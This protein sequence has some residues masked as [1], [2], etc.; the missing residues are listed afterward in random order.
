MTMIDWKRGGWTGSLNAWV[1]KEI[2][3]HFHKNAAVKRSRYPQF[4]QLLHTLFDNQTFGKFVAFYIGL[5]VFFGV[6]E[7][8]ISSYLSCYI[9][10]WGNSKSANTLISDLPVYLITAQVGV[11]S[12]VSI[13][14]GLISI[15]SQREDAA[16]DVQIYYHESLAFGVVASSIALLTIVILQLSWPLQLGLNWIFPWGHT[17]LSKLFLTLIHLAWLLLNLSAL[18]HFAAT[19]LAFVQRKSRQVLRE[20]YTSNVVLPAE[21][22]NNLRSQL[23]LQAGS[24]F[25]KEFTNNDTQRRDA[26]SVFTG[27][28]TSMNSEVEVSLKPTSNLTLHDV[29]MTFLR[30]TVMRWLKRCGN[31]NLEEGR[32]NPSFLTRTPSLYFPPT[33]D[34]TARPSEALCRRQGGLPLTRIEKLAIKM[35]FKFRKIANES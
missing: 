13:A 23:Y 16:T 6:S 24:E 18:A 8:A 12:V 33:L 14:I 3:E 11:L 28:N 17:N 34:S 27:F 26:F 15:I 22:W 2:R 31:S 7:L 20:R 9:N 1:S 21:M 10:Q 25:A 5:N 32:P 29:R 19:T 30:W 35:A 4:V